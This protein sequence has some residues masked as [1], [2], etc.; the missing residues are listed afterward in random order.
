MTK[1]LQ[2]LL[3]N[4]LG[5]STWAQCNR[6]AETKTEPIAEV[7]VAETTIVVMVVV[8]SARGVVLILGITT[9]RSTFTQRGMV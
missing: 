8:I 6:T 3:L 1:S 9:R 5:I 2:K 7:E 4:S